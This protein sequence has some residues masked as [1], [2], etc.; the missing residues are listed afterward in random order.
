MLGGREKG[1]QREK[2][3]FQESAIVSRGA[4]ICGP[5][6]WKGQRG[7]ID[8]GHEHYLFMKGG[9]QNG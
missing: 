2:K 9:K 7:G 4:R 3:K 8:R 1:E 5:P 6:S